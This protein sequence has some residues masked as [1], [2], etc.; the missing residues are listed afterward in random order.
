[1][2]LCS[3]GI[4]ATLFLVQAINCDDVIQWDIN[5]IIPCAGQQL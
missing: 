5:H 2:S 4:L 1:M 3:S